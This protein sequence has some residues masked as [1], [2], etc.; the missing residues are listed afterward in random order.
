ME[1]KPIKTKKEYETALK[2]LEALMDAKPGTPEGD[3][4]EIL[5]IL[6]NV[7]EE[8]KFPISAP[9]PIAAIYF[10][11]EQL[12]KSQK[13]FAKIIGSRSHASE[14]LRYKRS[15]SMRMARILHQNWGIP[16]D[17]LLKEY[18]LKDKKSVA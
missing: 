18:A 17:C 9:D 5:S 7:Y 8:K 6:L 12:G 15:L 14:V 16:S 11:M 3:R 1:I 2:E 4:L 13:D 10:R